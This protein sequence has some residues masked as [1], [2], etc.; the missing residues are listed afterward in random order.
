[1]RKQA[2]PK[3]SD[4]RRHKRSTAP[5][6][7]TFKKNGVVIDITGWTV[8]FT[9]KKNFEDTDA[10]AKISKKIT[11]H[12]DPTNGQTLI[13]FS[14]DETD[15]IGSYFYSI[16]YKDDDENEG[17]LIYGRIEFEDT[18]RTTRD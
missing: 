8:Y 4:L 9:L 14:A 5:Y 17:V 18:V 11:T 3:W 2:D 1:M 15:F 7:V 13:E 6:K 12:S 10:Q 16:E